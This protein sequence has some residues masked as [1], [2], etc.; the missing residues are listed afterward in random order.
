MIAVI[1][2]LL[3]VRDL[4][5]ASTVGHTAKGLFLCFTCIVS[6]RHFVWVV[7][8]LEVYKPVPINSA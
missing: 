6:H 8:L 3:V 5:S 4:F 2:V 1:H 7:F